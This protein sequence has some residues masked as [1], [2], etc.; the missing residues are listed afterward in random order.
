MFWAVVLTVSGL[1]LF[2]LLVLLA[3]LLVAVGAL[4]P[5]DE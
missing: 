2:G 5:N 1:A 4:R 3:G